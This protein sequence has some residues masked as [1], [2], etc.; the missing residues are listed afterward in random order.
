MD[1]SDKLHLIE[2]NS[3]PQVNHFIQNNGEAQIVDMYEKILAK[4]F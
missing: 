2:L 1:E 4:C 3:G